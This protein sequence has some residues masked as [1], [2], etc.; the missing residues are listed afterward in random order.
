MIILS[1]ILETT[2]YQASEDEYLLD[3]AETLTNILQNEHL[4]EVVITLKDYLSEP[5]YKNSSYRY[6]AVFNIIWHCAEN[7]TYP[8]F[9]K[10]IN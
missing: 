1:Q 4:P 10:A 3:I 6:D 5:H 7:M 9:H 2:Q 8:D